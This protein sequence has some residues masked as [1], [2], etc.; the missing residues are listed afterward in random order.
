VTFLTF[1]RG[2]RILWNG[3]FFTYGVAEGFPRFLFPCFPGASPNKEPEMGSIMAG[4]RITKRV[5]D[6]LK[7]QAGEYAVWDAQMPES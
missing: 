7:P 6:G 2:L 1:P 5:V 4:Q 3:Y